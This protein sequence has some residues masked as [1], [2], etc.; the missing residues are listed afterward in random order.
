MDVRRAAVYLTQRLPRDPRLYQIGVLS[1]L[2]AYGVA[3]LGFAVTL[4]VAVAILASAQGT[5]ALCGC[6]AGMPRFDPRSAMISALSLCLLLRTDGITPA[7]AAAALAVASKF[8]LRWRGKHLFNPSA[9]ALV[10][11]ILA[12]DR[13]WIS[14]GQWGTTAFVG[15]L[16]AC[17]GGVVV[18]R[19]ARADVTLAFLAAWSAIVLGRAAWLGDPLAVPLHRLQDGALLVFAFFMISDP[20]TTP[21]SRAGRLLFAALVAA[22]GVWIEVGLWRNQGPLFALVACAPLVPWIDRWLPAERY[23]WPAAVSRRA[24]AW[25]LRPAALGTGSHHASAAVS[26]A[27]ARIAAASSPGGR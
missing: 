1:T 13:A 3:R 23:R 27:A 19:A 26:P 10:A 17:L 7:A 22:V 20:K 25:L 16:V 12:T 5:Q 8:V 24:P 21:D 15:F 4:P 6:L 11:A 9:L 14:P 2:L 18:Q